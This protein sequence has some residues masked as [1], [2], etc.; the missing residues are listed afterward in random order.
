MLSSIAR[1]TPPGIHHLLQDISLRN[2]SQIPCSKGKHSVM[3]SGDDHRNYRQDEEIQQ[4]GIEG[5]E[6]SEESSPQHC[7]RTAQ[8]H[9]STHLRPFQT[10]VKKLHKRSERRQ[11]RRSCEEGEAPLTVL[12]PNIAAHR[13]L[14]SESSSCYVDRV[15]SASLSAS[16]LSFFSRSRQSATRISYGQ[17]KINRSSR[18][19]GPEGQTS[20]DSVSLDYLVSL[21]PAVIKRAFQRRRILEELINTE[22]SYIGDVKFLSSVC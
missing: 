10:W 8:A 19:S 4:C 11:H 20:E 6:V 15:H 12:P 3:V 18:T 14:S 5:P 13:S 9:G 17:E 2:C 21:E 7:E 22:E 16:A 1:L